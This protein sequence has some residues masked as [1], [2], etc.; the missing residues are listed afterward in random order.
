MAFRWVTFWNS[1]RTTQKS[2]LER[3][4]EQPWSIGIEGVVRRSHQE[5][6]VTVIDEIYLT[7]ASIV[8]GSGD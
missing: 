2:D 5:G 1:R 4:V 6:D 8:K 3:F 7:G